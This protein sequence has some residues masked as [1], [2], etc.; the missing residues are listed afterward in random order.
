MRNINELNRMQYLSGIKSTRYKILREDN[1]NSFSRKTIRQ[2]V[3]KGVLFGFTGKEAGYL[4][5]IHFRY[6]FRKKDLDKANNIGIID[7]SIYGI[8]ANG[9]DWHLTDLLKIQPDLK[10]EI[11]KYLNSKYNEGLSEGKRKPQCT[12]AD[13]RQKKIAIDTVKNPKKSLLGGPSAQEAE[14][15]LRDKFNYNDKM[16]AKLK[17]SDLGQ[18]DYLTWNYPELKS[19]TFTEKE[20][21][22]K[23]PGDDGYEVP[24]VLYYKVHRDPIG[25]IKV[26]SNSLR[27]TSDIHHPDNDYAKVDDDF[28]NNYL[29]KDTNI[30]KDYMRVAQDYEDT[31]RDWQKRRNMRR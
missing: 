26:I 31:W 16:I 10:D 4:G 8:D 6:Y 27:G 24:G 23:W 7:N 14:K 2:G 25:K 13:K 30:K 21:K 18:S 17:E 15:I 11:L 28:I 1:T 22:V 20:I 12:L 29:L 5:D 19:S 9:N 3:M